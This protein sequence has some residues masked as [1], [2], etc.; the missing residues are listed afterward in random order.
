MKKMRKR[1]LNCAS[2]LVIC[3]IAIVFFFSDRSTR[4]ATPN[5][6]QEEDFYKGKVVRIIVSATPGGGHDNYA[7]LYAA[8]LPRFLSGARVVVQNVP[9]AGHLIGTNKM[10]E[11]K[12]DGL[13]MAS[14][15]RSMIFSQLIE[16]K[17]M[18]F[19]MRKFNWL[20]NMAAEP[21]LLVVGKNSPFK[22]LEDI[23]KG[24]AEIKIGSNG[25]ATTSYT[26][27]VILEEIFKWPVNIVLGY[28]GSNEFVLATIKGEVDACISVYDTA[29]GA[30]ESGDLK[31]VLQMGGKKIPGLENIPL[32]HELAGPE[33]KDLMR[34]LNVQYSVSRLV[35]TAPGVPEARVA[36][37][38][39]VFR[40]MA[41]DKEFLDTAQKRNLPIDFTPGEELQEWM[42]G[43]MNQP[44]K[45][46]DLLKKLLSTTD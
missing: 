42:E 35:T 21:R 32:L 37:L 9:G 24:G 31:A 46:I 22:T 6:T 13:T 23:V 36:F 20:A 33:W 34:V 38:R 41:H 39:D 26:D 25:R 27:A 5:W 40:R 16:I 43:A 7:R 18:R 44:Q 12:P 4:A 8:H 28:T 1:S 14:I 11:S 29:Q 10:Y 15:I 19:D 3:A 45:V 17:G 30:L 2:M